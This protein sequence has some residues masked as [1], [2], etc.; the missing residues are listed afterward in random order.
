MPPLLNPLIEKTCLHL[1]MRIYTLLHMTII[2]RIHILTTTTL[3]TTITITTI[4]TVRTKSYTPV[5]TATHTDEVEVTLMNARAAT[6]WATPTLTT[7]TI[8]RK[9]SSALPF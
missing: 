3:T 5:H 6:P 7:I 1:A 2:C 4:L 9:R 8:T